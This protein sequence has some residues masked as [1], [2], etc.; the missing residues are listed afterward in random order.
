MLVTYLKAIT[1]GDVLDVGL[2]SV[3]IYTLLMWFK[4]ARAAFI[5]K[6]MV[7]T[8][9][10]YLLA[11]VA[12]MVMTTTL[13]HAFFAILALAMVVIFQEELRRIFER[14]AVWSLSGGKV[15]RVSHGPGIEVIVSTVADL[16]AERTGALVVLRGRDPLDRHLQGGWSLSGV[17]SEPLL[18]SIFDRHSLG[19]DGAVIVEDQQVTHFGSRLPLSRSADT[20]SLGTRHAAALG[21]AEL[22]DAL[23]VVVSEERGTI[24]VAHEGR[25][26]QV[27]EPSE[28]VVRLV[29]FAK[30][31]QP[32]TSQN[33]LQQ[34]RTRATPQKLIA[35]ASS[36]VLW[37]V[38]VF[39]VKVAEHQFEVDV[40]LR[41]VP[42]GLS[43]GEVSPPVARVT[44]SAQIKDFL[45]A[46]WDP[47]AVRLDL[48]GGRDGVNRIPIA[49]PYVVH[50]P[51]FEVT[52]IEPPVIEVDLQRSPPPAA[53]PAPGGE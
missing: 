28:L 24:S 2:L 45:W 26:E 15:V 8:G 38:F 14:I 43:A 16:A 22:T 12:G 7:V 34:L 33:R 39:G 6:G 51:E 41:A 13:F 4:R 48:S 1:I 50:P 30:A 9:A 32:A 40:Q 21:L 5:V 11:R 17:L 29:T 42:A 53:A 10:V 49:L 37:V 3:L 18:K 23:C 52:I 46:E 47:V 25:L 44:V 35:I 19:H 20:G 36:L 31:I 27:D